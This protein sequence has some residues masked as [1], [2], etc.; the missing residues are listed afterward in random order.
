MVGATVVREEVVPLAAAT[1]TTETKVG[2]DAK[3][4]TAKV[5]VVN[6]EVE[7]DEVADT[8]YFREINSQVVDIESSSEIR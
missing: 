3:A 4:A 8:G 6:A 2:I 5:G 1:T 7:E